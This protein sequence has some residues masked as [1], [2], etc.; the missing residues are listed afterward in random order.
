VKVT[1]AICTWNRADLL[2]Q[3]LAKMMYV[4]IP[5]GVRWEL[6]VI[7]NNST[8]RTQSV[9]ADHAARMP[10]RSLVEASPGQSN[11]RN[12]A[13]REARGD[14]II[15]TDDDV[16]VDPEWLAAYVEAAARW[17][18]A[19]FF[20]GPITP[21]FEGD[22]PRWLHRTYP[23]IANAYAAR[24]LGQE[25]C[26]LT[27]GKFPFGAN[28]AI[29]TN[30]QRRYLFDPMLGLKPRSS[31][32]GE[33][34][35]VFGAMARDGLE[36]RWVPAAKVQHFIQKTRQSIGYLRSYYRGL[37][38]LQASEIKQEEIAQMLGAQRWAWRSA[39]E[40]EL[41]FWL[42]RYFVDPE[43]WIDNF[44]RANLSWGS[45][46]PPGPN[47]ARSRRTNPRSQA[48]IGQR[49]AGN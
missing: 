46:F 19:S 32:R 14:L 39:V 37:G 22:P 27:E 7:D 23:T 30:V 20:G 5:D 42:K 49:R 41:L 16:L 1:V 3:T 26:P 6:L 21:L 8:D 44:V 12:C 38:Q 2:D 29:R 9:L 36:G 10:I 11:A 24:D 43:S 4:R 47:R 45:L 48:D 15:W 13:I 33:E 17:T 31:I 25:A 35:A 28:M 40:N 34:I 18:T